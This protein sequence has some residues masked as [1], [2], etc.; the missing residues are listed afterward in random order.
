MKGIKYFLDCYA[1]T[2]WDV[3][4]AHPIFVSFQL[5]KQRTGILNLSK[6]D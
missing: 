5:K 2:E 4:F 6:L 3:F 1:I